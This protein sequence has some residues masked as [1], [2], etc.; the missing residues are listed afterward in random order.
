MYCNDLE[1]YVL[2]YDIC[3]EEDI[4]CVL[5]NMIYAG[6]YQRGRKTNLGEWKEKMDVE[7]Y[8][9]WTDGRGLRMQLGVRRR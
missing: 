6:K 9:S 7:G 8:W 2:I 5:P 1:I 3:A 4:I